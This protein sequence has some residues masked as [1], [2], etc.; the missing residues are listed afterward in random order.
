MQAKLFTEEKIAEVVIDKTKQVAGYEKKTTSVRLNHPGR[1]PLPD[2]LPREVIRLE[3]E[4]NVE[5][6]KPVGEEVTEVLEYRSAQLYVKQFIRPKYLK[7]I[8]DGLSTK[9]II[10]PLPCLPIEKSYCG[11]S[12][13]SHLMISKY[14]DHLPIYRQMQIFSRNKITLPDNTVSNWIQKGCNLLIPLYEAHKRHVLDTKYLHVDETTIKVQD[15]T[16]KGVT[17]QGYYWVYY[18]TLRKTVLFEYQ[19]GRDAIFPRE[20]LKEYQGYLQCDGYSGYEQFENKNGITVL[21]CWAHARRKFYDAQTFDKVK[22]E[23]V[24]AQIQKLYAVEEMCREGNLDADHIRNHRMQFALPVL[25]KLHNILH[26][27]LHITLP[28]SPLGKAIQ[29]TLTR[30]NKLNQYLEDGNLKI[31]NNLIENS[32][33]PVAIGRKNYLFAGSHDAAQNAAMLYSLFATCR[34]HNLN[35]ETWLT[36]VLSHIADIKVNAIHQWLPQ[37]YKP[38]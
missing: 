13:L 15:K 23:E 21:N 1:N 14:V 33:R 2:S 11:A 22:A 5:A 32:I 30:W 29:Y 9:Q 17:H 3:P 36:Q 35:P 28:N 24:L 34:L 26:Q 19:K 20:M 38:E 12:L 37:N 6:L 18:N 16:K 10:A 8:E 27:Q 7:P 31:D 4:E 25:N